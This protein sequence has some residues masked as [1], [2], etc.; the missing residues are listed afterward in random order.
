MKSNQSG[1]IFFEPPSLIGCRG[2]EGRGFFF[3]FFFPF[4]LLVVVYLCVCVSVVG[5]LVGL[6][7]L[8][9]GERR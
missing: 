1:T 5:S 2:A 9:Q 7:A 4:F 8:T 3:L 6:F